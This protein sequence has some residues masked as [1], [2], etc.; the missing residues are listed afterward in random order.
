MNILVSGSRGFIGRSLS[1][2][3]Q[4]LGSS[5]TPVYSDLLLNERLSPPKYDNSEVFIHLAAR[6]HSEKDASL[7]VFFSDNVE[8]TRKALDIALSAGVKKFILFSSI[9]VYGEHFEDALTAESTCMPKTA[10]GISKLEAE[11]VAVNFCRKHSIAIDIVRIPIVIG[12]G[13]KGNIGSLLKFINTGLPIPFAGID[14][15]RSNVDLDYLCKY[16]SE[17]CY[18]KADGRHSFIHLVANPEPESTEQLVAR[19]AT[20]M[21]KKAFLIWVPRFTLNFTAVCSDF[22]SGISGIKLP[23]GVSSIEK[24]TKGLTVVPGVYSLS[25][26]NKLPNNRSGEPL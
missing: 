17:L 14:A 8:A 26:N 20:M 9:K 12:L 21:N 2:R 18:K 7:K 13:A 16:V 24:V 1:K 19:L 11:K 4:G 6:V 22:L 25:G 15:K 5:I 3:L 23:F 10:Y